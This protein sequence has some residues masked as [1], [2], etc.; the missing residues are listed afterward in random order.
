MEEI[1]KKDQLYKDKIFTINAVRIDF[2]NG[3]VGTYELVE[4][5]SATSDGIDGV[6]AVPVDRNN[7]VYLLEQYQVGADKRLLI[8]PRGGVDK[9]STPDKQINEELREE[10]GY[11]ANKITKLTNLDIFPGWYKGVTIL[12]LAQ[13]LVKDPKKGDELDDLKLRIV[14]YAKIYDMIK[15]GEITDARTIAGL[16][17]VKNYLS[18]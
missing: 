5:T 10:I 13:Y 7:R 11:C 4:S 3:N 1:I 18:L 12:Y 6:M 9:G 16:L 2:G 15:S 17:F 8:L 14:D